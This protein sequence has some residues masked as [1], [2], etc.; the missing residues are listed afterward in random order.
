MKKPSGLCECGCG[1]RTNIATA[2][3]AKNGH[4]KGW[5]MRYIANHHTRKSPHEFLEDEKT[6]CWVW[7]RSR[8]PEGYGKFGWQGKFYRAHRWFY[9]TYSGPVPE[10]L[11]MDHLCR[12]RACVNPGHLEPVTQAE[13]IQRKK[14]VKLSVV[15]VQEIRSLCREG[16]RHRDIASAYGIAMGYVSHLANYRVWGAV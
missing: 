5:P 11:V 6:G 14:D 2:D 8:V 4:V 7:Q 3:H 12:N 1:E 15:S 13:N 16:W 10:G 9:E